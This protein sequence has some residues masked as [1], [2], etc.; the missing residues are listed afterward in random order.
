MFRKRLLLLM[1]VLLLFTLPVSADILWEPYDNTYY[2]MHAAGLEY[3][4]RTHIVP[5]GMTANVYKSP[6]NG[7]L[8]KTLE[9]GTKLYVGPYLTIRGETW[10]ASYVL[11]DWETEGWVRL[12]RLQRKYE[13]ED[14][15]NDFGDLCVATDDQLT[16]QDIET[17]IHTWTYPGSGE[18]ELS[19]P[20]EALG[21]GYNGGVMDFRYVYTDPDGGRWGYVGYF[22]GRCGWVYLDDP[23]TLDAPIFPQATENTV[24][25][26]APE[27][28]PQGYIGILALIAVLAIGSACAIIVLKKKSR[29]T[30][31]GDFIHET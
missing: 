5:E 24:T 6:S 26:T 27:R 10:G 13:H 17:E 7:G 16:Q 20:R 14:F 1:L 8:I 18:L 9:A 15:Y 22:M 12:D 19:I 29:S 4:D 11:G 3:M 30:S 28:A 31:G 21:G 25:D 23:D 2:Q